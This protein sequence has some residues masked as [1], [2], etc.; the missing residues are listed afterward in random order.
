M[1]TGIYPETGNK[2][3]LIIM[4]TDGHPFDGMSA[5]G[6]RRGQLLREGIG[7]EV[8]P[9]SE[10]GQYALRQIT[11]NDIEAVKK[12][13]ER[14]MGGPVFEMPKEEKMAKEKREVEQPANTIGLA[15]L[16]GMGIG[17]EKPTDERVNQFVKANEQTVAGQPKAAD[18]MVKPTQ[19]ELRPVRRVPIYESRKEVLTAPERPGFH[20]HFINDIDDRVQKALNAGYRIVE[21]E[22]IQ[23]GSDYAGKDNPLG[24]AR[25]KHVGKGM[26]AVLMEI[27]IEFYEEDQ[28]AKQRLND[29][30]T[31]TMQRPNAANGQYGGIYIG[32]G[33]RS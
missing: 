10:K 13:I 28:K 15:D 26:K 20:R 18:E 6:L 27:P 21:D 11:Q 12:E 25:V 23:I 22:S 3:P 8:I 9:L 33:I 31:K 7:T 5:A 14:D 17:K 4:R 2:Y 29:E 16:I 32:D 1:T 19:K 30:R 24:R